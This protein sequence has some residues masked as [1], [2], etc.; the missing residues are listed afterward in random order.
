M[1]NRRGIII[2]PEELD[3]TWP[4]RLQDARLNVLGIHPVGGKD[5]HL[6]LES[7]IHHRLLPETQCLFKQLNH[8]GIAVEYE[9]HTMAWLLP[10]TLIH[11][12]PGWFRMDRQGVR[13][14]RSSERFLT[15]FR[16]LCSS[17]RPGLSPSRR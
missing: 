4:E 14:P 9:A 3:S 11:S 1:E 15:A 10:R 13:T 6:S 8:L 17:A 2:H 7:A 12:K 5:A 16:G